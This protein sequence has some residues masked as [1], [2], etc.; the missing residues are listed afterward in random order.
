MSVRKHLEAPL[1]NRAVITTGTEIWHGQPVP[2]WC[3]PGMACRSP[4]LFHCTYEEHLEGEGTVYRARTDGGP[5]KRL[6][7]CSD[8]LAVMASDWVKRRAG[9]SDKSTDAHSLDER[10]LPPSGMR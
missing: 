6:G 7:T 8:N 4:A 9:L 1:G 3:P 10:H 5:L 2:P